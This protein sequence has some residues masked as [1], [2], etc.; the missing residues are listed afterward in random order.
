MTL[1]R[2]WR[3]LQLLSKFGSTF[4]RKSEASSIFCK[5]VD[6]NFERSC[7]VRQGLKM[8]SNVIELLEE[9]KKKRMVQ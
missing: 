1:L 2:P 5:N 3:T 8:S 4:A 9:T 6:P 7:K